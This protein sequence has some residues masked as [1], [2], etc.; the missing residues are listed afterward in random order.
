MNTTNK[1]IEHFEDLRVWQEARQLVKSVYHDLREGEGCCDFSFKKQIQSAGISIMNNI[2]EGF[3]RSTNADF[4]RFLDI[5]KGSSGEVRSM[6]YVAEDLHYVS[7]T[8]AEAR[9]SIAIGISKGIA[10]LTNHLRK[11]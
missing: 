3:E 9:R 8:T 6:S 7:T 2:A 1:S 4:T 10:S 5:A 11:K